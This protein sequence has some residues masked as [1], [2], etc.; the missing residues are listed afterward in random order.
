MTK[1]LSRQLITLE[2]WQDIFPTQWRR[3]QHRKLD[4]MCQTVENFYKQTLDIRLL[5]DKDGQ[6]TFFRNV[7]Y[8]DAS[9][10]VGDITLRLEARSGGYQLGKDPVRKLSDFI[11]ALTAQTGN[12]LQ[13]QD[14][15]WD[16]LE[17]RKSR[18]EQAS[19]K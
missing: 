7:Y 2:Q 1:Q 10:K 3:I 15:V 18:I 11:Q 8:Q 17:K 6:S 19:S 16:V 14:E 4:H 9:I 5:F 12:T 13:W